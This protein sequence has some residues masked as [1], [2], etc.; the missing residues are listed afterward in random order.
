MYYALQPVLMIL[1]FIIAIGV[2]IWAI[3]DWDQW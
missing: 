3:N 1:V 2:L